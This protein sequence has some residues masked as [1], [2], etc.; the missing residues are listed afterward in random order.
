[1]PA[2]MAMTAM[3][4]P[5]LTVVPIST[6]HSVTTPADGAGTSM[7]ALSDSSSTSESPSCT[8]VPAGTRISTR[9]APSSL[10]RSGIVTSI[11][12]TALDASLSSDSGAAA[13]VVIGVPGTGAVVAPP[14]WDA[15][16]SVSFMPS[17]VRITSPSDTESPTA[18]RSAPTTPA[19]GAGI[20]M[21]AL[22]DSTTTRLCSTS[23]VS[24]GE[25]K[26]STTSAPSAPP[27]SGTFISSSA[28][29]GLLFSAQTR[30]G[31]GL[32]VSIP[33]CEMA[34][35]TTFGSRSP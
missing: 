25:T 34:C 6:R 14:V 7:E 31:L 11:V 27:I 9:S 4:T 22:S 26:T 33:N 17:S 28:I 2:R 15:G 3:T 21:E 1:M 16:D 23:I 32:S 18:T 10:P 13:A 19:I 20:S 30:I 12:V 8:S 5:S 29:S 35:S 24:P